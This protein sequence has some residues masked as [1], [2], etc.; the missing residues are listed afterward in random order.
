VLLAGGGGGAGSSL[1]PPLIAMLAVVGVALL[2]VLYVRLV[3]GSA[4][5]SGTSRKCVVCLME[6]ADG[7]ELRALPLCAH[8]FHS[9]CIDGWLHAHASCPL[10]RAAVALPPPV[11]LRAPA[12]LTSRASVQ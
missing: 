6:F 5:G 1:S 12:P 7:D 3:S 10:C 2:L 9:D 8:A 11:W 4:R